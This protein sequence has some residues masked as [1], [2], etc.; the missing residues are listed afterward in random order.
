MKDDTRRVSQ[1]PPEA[2]ATLLA[3]LPGDTVAFLTHQRVTWREASGG[4]VVL[5]LLLGVLAALLLGR[6]LASGQRRAG[7]RSTA[8]SP[9]RW[10]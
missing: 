8:T 4:S 3:E 9:R 5:A 7:T 2:V 6:R 10:R 1:R